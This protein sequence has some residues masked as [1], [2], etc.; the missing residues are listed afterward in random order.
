MKRA[1]RRHHRERLKKVRKDY[2]WWWTTSEGITPR[3]LGILLNTACL[4]SCY[5]CTNDRN[6]RGRDNRSHKEID[7]E[8]SFEEQ[9]LEYLSDQKTATRG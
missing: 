8:V 6:R 3:A 9:W 7:F 4:C 2:Y 1:I 5:G